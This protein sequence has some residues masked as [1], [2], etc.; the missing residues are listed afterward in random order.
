MRHMLTLLAVVMLPGVGIGSAHAA[1]GESR[2]APPSIS[3]QA[4]PNSIFGGSPRTSPLFTIGGFEVRVWAPVASPYTA[5][6]NGDLAAGDI[7]SAG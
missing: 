6:A 3:I 2:S 7:W 1:G 5:K 4:E